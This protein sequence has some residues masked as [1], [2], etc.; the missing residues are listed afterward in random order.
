MYQ[1]QT[2]FFWQSEIDRYLFGGYTVVPQTTTI[3]ISGEKKF[4]SMFMNPPKEREGDSI[5]DED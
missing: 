5:T 1:V 3:V 4:F 2:V